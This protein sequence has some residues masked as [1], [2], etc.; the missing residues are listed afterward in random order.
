MDAIAQ[1]R[2]V[3]R[4]RRDKSIDVA[5]ALY[6]DTLKQ[7]ATLEQ[8]LIGQQRRKHR[9]VP[10]CMQLAMPADRPFT[11]VDVQAALE[12][13]EPGRVWYQRTVANNLS[14]LCRRG[15]LKRLK[16]CRPQHPAV[17]VRATATTET[18][19]TEPKTLLDEAESLLWSRSMTA[20]ELVVSL[21]EF[22]YETPMT[23][24][25]LQRELL[26]GMKRSPERFKLDDGERWAVQQQA[27]QN[28]ATAPLQCGPS[29]GRP[30]PL[31]T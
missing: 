10:E 29:V 20:T 17:Y 12:A 7:I 16:R 5:E 19:P 3:A 11:S 23:P 6:A 25:L 14:R 13:L 8:D 1:L 22:G 31:W 15:F 21:L 18:T 30:A 26:A 27:C 28:W 9:A 4:E 2:R 24:T